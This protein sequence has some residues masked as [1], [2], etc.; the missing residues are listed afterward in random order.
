LIILVPLYALTYKSLPLSA[1]PMGSCTL[2]A[3]V[4]TCAC[5]AARQRIKSKKIKNFF[6]IESFIAVVKS[7]S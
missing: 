3:T 6:I 1:V 2:V 4:V 7:T 5:A